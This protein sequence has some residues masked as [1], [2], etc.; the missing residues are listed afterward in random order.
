MLLRAITLPLEIE[1]SLWGLG[2]S[3]VLSHPQGSDLEVRQ[4][5]LAT[6]VEGDEIDIWLAGDVERFAFDSRDQSIACMAHL[7]V[8]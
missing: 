7:C 8:D 6:P 1:I 5:V 4:W 3:A 2:A